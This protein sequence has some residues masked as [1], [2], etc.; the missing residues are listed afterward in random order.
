[1]RELEDYQRRIEKQ[2]IESIVKKKKQ[3]EYK[4]ESSIRPHRGHKLFEINIKTFEIN[5]A[6][7]IENKTISWQEA[8]MLLNGTSE[9]E[10]VI[11]K[12]CVYISAL[13]KESA[14]KRLKEDRGS[15]VK[16]KGELTLSMF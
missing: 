3:V 9:K 10:V 6:K 7:Y 11:E 14:L 13:N 8:Q 1:M 2:A 16:P 5:E 4:Y 15:A 12:H